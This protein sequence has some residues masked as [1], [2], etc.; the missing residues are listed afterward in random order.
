MNKRA[1]LYFAALLGAMSPLSTVTA[2]AAQSNS[3]IATA[4]QQQNSC[5]G[6][7]KDASGE[8]IIGATIRIDGKTGGTVTDL[9][10]NFVLNNLTKGAKLT[11]TYVGY[12]AQT[13]TWNGTP[14][15]I[16]MQDDANVLEE[17]VVIGYGTVKKADLAGSVA[18]M[19]GKS[20][21]DRLLHVL[22]M[23]STVVCLVYR[24]CLVAY[25]VVP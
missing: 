3:A 19:E 7:V 6:T 10:G 9:D 4:T 5:K 18:V 17:T 21:K 15:D 12:K 8:P 14:L 13:I 25:L 11:I 16:T 1:N 24:L 20:F 2:L 22:R 23:P